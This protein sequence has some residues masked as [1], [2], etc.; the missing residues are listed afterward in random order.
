MNTLINV[1]VAAKRHI[2]D[3][4][5][6]F[7]LEAVDGQALPPYEAGAHV[8]VHVPGGPV[9]QY[10]LHEP[11]SVRG[12]YHIGVL[13]DP[14]SRGGSARLLDSVQEGDTLAISA[15]RN[16]F[17]LHDDPKSHSVLF[18]GGIGI[19]PILCMAKQLAGEGRDFAMHYCGRTAGRMAFVDELGTAQFAS[20]VHVHADDGPKDQQL[21]ARSAIGTPADGLHG[22]RARHGALARL[23]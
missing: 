20:R 11:P 8:D 19:T 10:S 17:A 2:A 13:R 14:Q 23:G 5:A 12:R 7:V 4:T 6:G 9:R 3:D 15:P 21:D 18:A 1:R 22:P 16:H